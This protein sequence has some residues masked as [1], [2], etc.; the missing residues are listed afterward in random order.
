M[1]AAP[2]QQCSHGGGQTDGQ[3]GL[4]IH[5]HGKDARK[6]GGTPG[7]GGPDSGSGTA[8]PET[9]QTVLRAQ[10]SVPDTGTRHGVHRM[11]SPETAQQCHEQ[12]PGSALQADGKGCGLHIEKIQSLMTGQQAEQGKKSPE[13]GP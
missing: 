6:N 2:G 13:R 10:S 5:A 11:R 8:T 1:A 7:S 4:L 12:Q 3:G 9:A